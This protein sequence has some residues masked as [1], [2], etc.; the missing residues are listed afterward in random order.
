[1][2][3]KKFCKEIERI[4]RENTNER[5]SFSIS[6]SLYEF[7][8]YERKFQICILKED[9]KQEDPR[10]KNFFI[11]E[12]RNEKQALKALKACFVPVPEKEETFVII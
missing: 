4:L 2:K 11:R 3:I 9:N 6:Y 5:L 12:F 1:M 8:E 10:I 7:D